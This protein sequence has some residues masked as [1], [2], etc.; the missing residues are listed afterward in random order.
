MKTIYP[1]MP[2]AEELMKYFLNLVKQN[3]LLCI[4][5]FE[6]IKTKTAKKE[7]IKEELYP[8]MFNDVMDIVKV[9]YE[10]DDTKEEDEAILESLFELLEAHEIKTKITNKII[11]KYVI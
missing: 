2:F 6:N 4:D 7:Y 5:E 10:I 1:G 8:S 11:K 9:K 3:D